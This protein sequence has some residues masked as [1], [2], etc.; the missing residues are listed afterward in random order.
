MSKILVIE[1]DAELRGSMTEILKFEKHTVYAAS[2]GSEGLLM[3]REKNPEII[4]CDILMPGIDG[5]EVLEELKNYI[6]SFSIPFIYITALAE[7]QDV[8]HG[9]DLGADDYL[10]KPFTRDE[11]LN[12]INSRLEKRFQLALSISR[13]VDQIEQELNE[14]LNLLTTELSLQKKTLLLI[15]D[16]NQKLNKEL[17]EKKIELLK[18][19]GDIIEINNKLSDFKKVITAELQKEN[20]MDEQKNMFLDLKR[21]LSRKSIFVNNLTI[22][23][24][25]FN[26]ANPQFIP[27]FM[28]QLPNMTQHEV[29]F[30]SALIMGLNNNQIANLLNITVDSVR[31][32]KFRLKK[33]IGLGSESNLLEY[34]H[35]IC[36]EN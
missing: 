31:K 6:N 24:I 35:S 5:F 19:A 8:R 7:R 13:S 34:L 33:K 9:M 1:D 4:L 20:I 3:A 23:Q 22:F 26:Q 29:T 28:Q 10:T 27:R 12:T 17:E 11:F 15:S 25:Q 32:S 30:V 14:K 2:N 18:S 21:R 16:L 36:M